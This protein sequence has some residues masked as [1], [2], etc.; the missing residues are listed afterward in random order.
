M[1]GPGSPFEVVVE[2]VAFEG[3]NLPHHKGQEYKVFKNMMQTLTDLYEMPIAKGYGPKE[4]LVYDD[5][6][7]TYNQVFQQAGQ[8]GHVLVD[9]FGVQNGDRV[10]IVSRNCPE[11]LIAF[12]AATSIGA[13]AV[14]MNSWWTTKE[15]EYGLENSGSRVVFCDQDRLKHMLPILDSLKDLCGVVLM[16]GGNTDQHEKIQ[17]FDQ[18]VELGSGFSMP[19]NSATKDDNAVLMYTSGTTGHPKGVVMTHRG[20]T[21]ALNAVA[22]HHIV[23]RGSNEKSAKKGSL[24]KSI[25]LTV[26]LFHATGL[27]MIF[28]VSIMVCR[29][30]VMMYK[31]DPEKALQLIERERVTQFTG[32]PTMVLEMMQ[33]PN[34]NQYDTSSLEG[35]GGGG[36]PPPPSI[37][38][39]IGTKFKRASA[40]QGYGATE[41]NAVLC[42]IASQDY[43]ARPKSCGKPLPTVELE[44]WDENGT[45]LPPNIPGRVMARGANIMKEYWRKPEATK[46]AITANGFYETGDVGQLD[47]EGF[48]YILGRNKLD[49]VIRGGE[50]ISSAEVEGVI[51]SIKGVAEASVFGIP[52]PT[53]GEEVAVAIFQD[54]EYAGEI[55]LRYIQNACRDILANFKIPTRLFIWPTRLPRGATG[56][57]LKRAIKEQVMKTSKL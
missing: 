15:L 18:V 45:K 44:I 26:P 13:V 1:F 54:P 34:F 24:E 31:W 16:R 46:K 29:K 10:C 56:K 50:N 38:G 53:L 12:I 28:L 20:I 40:G 51:F 17:S 5:E 47:D 19:A 9:K 11:Y 48:L 30:I 35:V 27:H 41:T 6:R 36:A 7:L 22:V 49:M 3:S 42:V 52:H 37:V 33:C 43:A 32:V 23:Q 25:M 4:F 14:R 21:H 39:Q 8:L 2:K 57:T 55:T